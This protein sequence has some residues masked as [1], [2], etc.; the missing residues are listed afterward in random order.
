M[1]IVALTGP[2]R[3]GIYSLLSGALSIA[4]LCKKLSQR[5]YGVS[6][7]LTSFFAVPDIFHGYFLRKIFCCE[8]SFYSCHSRGL[9][10]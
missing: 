4:G 6:L 3:A 7:T 9:K 2:G 1:R 10:R 8:E 5:V